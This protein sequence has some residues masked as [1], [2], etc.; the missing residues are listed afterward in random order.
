MI[1]ARNTSVQSAVQRQQRLDQHI[2]AFG[3][4]LRRRILQ[5]AVAVALHAGHEDHRRGQNVRHVLRVVPRAAVD[6]HR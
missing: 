1:A 4:G 6:A 2:H 5:L 3:A